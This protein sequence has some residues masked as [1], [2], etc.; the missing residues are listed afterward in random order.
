M[1]SR[2]SSSLPSLNIPNIP[3]SGVHHQTNIQQ[4]N[5]RGKVTCN[6][7]C[8]TPVLKPTTISRMVPKK[9]SIF[10]TAAQA[11]SSLFSQGEL[12]FLSEYLNF[13]TILFDPKSFESLHSVLCFVRELLDLFRR[14]LPLVTINKPVEL[15]LLF[16][17]SKR[18][19]I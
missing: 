3:R 5:K 13:P 17:R 18:E 15:F 4:A 8:K 12:N 2:S 7:G 11:V 9:T 19:P 10:M 16:S 6:P 14:L 1:S